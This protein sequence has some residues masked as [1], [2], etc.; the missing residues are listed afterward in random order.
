MIVE[1]TYTNI[2]LFE[3]KLNVYANIN[4]VE[5]TKR[6][7]T[8]SLKNHNVMYI[9]HLSDATYAM[10]D[11]LYLY[12]FVL[13]KKIPMAI[14]PTIPDRMNMSPMFPASLCPF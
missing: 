7:K 12:L 9:I 2:K 5:I 11:Y 6:P 1:I 14:I 3:G 13:S 8:V 10:N 4:I